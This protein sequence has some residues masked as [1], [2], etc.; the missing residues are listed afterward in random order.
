VLVSVR[1]EVLLRVI[2]G[3]ATVDTSWQGIVLH[4]RYLVVRAI[5]VLKEK[6]GSPVVGEVLAQELAL[7]LG[8]FSL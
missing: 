5:R 8:L 7:C 4:D 2:D 6:H 1:V 3:H